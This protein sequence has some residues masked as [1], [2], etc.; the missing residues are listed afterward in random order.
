MKMNKPIILIT[1]LALFSSAIM[2]QRFEGGLIL[3][4]N[5]TQIDGDQ[6]AGYNKLGFI[7]GGYIKNYFSETISIQSG[8]SYSGKGSKAEFTENGVVIDSRKIG[9]HYI[10]IPFLVNY[11]GKNK[12][13]FGA[14]FSVGYLIA[15][16]QVENGYEIDKDMYNYK[17][18]D[19][20]A[21]LSI[22]YKI[23]ERF[24]G[25]LKLSYSV[26]SIS[27]HQ[28]MSG[29]FNNAVGLLLEYKF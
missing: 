10:E 29:Q 15:S 4:F 23:S 16:K 25:K 26:L 12:F 24:C 13:I 9:L 27:D 3:G 21:D 20:C 7:G 5:G 11:T 18:F 8:I 19:Y 14:G 1:M 2:A 17:D 28:G 22:G 6:S